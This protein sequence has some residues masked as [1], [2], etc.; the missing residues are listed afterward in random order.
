MDINEVLEKAPAA[1]AHY[2]E[3]ENSAYSMM[4]ACREEYKRRWAAE[5]LERKIT[6]GKKSIREIEC[7]MEIKVELQKIKEKEMSSETEYRAWRVKRDKAVNMFIA[8]QELGRTRRTE[9]KSLHDTV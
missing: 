6:A 4:V 1:I 7:E 9:L 3:K 2:A 8:A 5:F